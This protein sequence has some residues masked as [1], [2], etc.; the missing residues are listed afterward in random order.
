MDGI[1]YI[2]TSMSD[3]TC[4]I[5]DYNECDVK[6]DIVIGN[7]VSYQGVES[8]DEK[9]AKVYDLNGRVVENPA[10]GIYIINGKKIL[11]K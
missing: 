5:V 10:N 2:P 9:I 4:C 1:E 3:R 7:T 8:E 6:K 11:V